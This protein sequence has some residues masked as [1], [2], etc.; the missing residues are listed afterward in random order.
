MSSGLLSRRSLRGAT[1][2][3]GGRSWRPGP[4]LVFGFL[5]WLVMSLA[6]WAA[7]LCCEAGLH[8][9]VIERLRVDLW[10][11]RHPLADLPVAGSPHYSPYAVAQGLFARLTG[12]GGW[13]VVRLAGPLNLLVL[14]TGL[15]RLVRVLTPRPWAPVL[16]LPVLLMSGDPGSPAAFAVGLSLWAWALTGA[17]ARNDGALRYVG[18]SGLPGIAGYVGPGVLYGTVLLVDPVT[19]VGAVAGAVAFVAGWQRG[20]GRAVG[21]RWAVTAGVAVLVAVGWPYFG[22][23]APE[24]VPVPWRFWPAL[25]GLPAL[26]ARGRR[27]PLTLMFVLGCAVAVCGYGGFAGLVAPVCA[28]AVALAAPRPWGARR[29]VYTG[30]AAAVACLGLLTVPRP[31]APPTYEWAARHIGRGEV[32]LTADRHAALALAGF[33]ANLVP[34]GPVA[35]GHE[36]DVRAYLAPASTR[37]DRAAVVRRHRVRW[38]LLTRQDRV[39]GEAVVVA[40]SARTGEVLARVVGAV[41]TATTTR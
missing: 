28:A 37:A 36:P 13:E 19:A 24:R 12:L 5:C 38:L 29:K 21:V 25:V 18:P 9:A 7:P 17:R 11:P 3:R 30:V 15:G 41:P 32:V 1:A 6:Y 39:P 14:L 2:L 4:Y 35:Q 27:D 8:A 40:W 31:A 16:A 20:W 33:G 22:L 23:V 26:W 10:H 34:P